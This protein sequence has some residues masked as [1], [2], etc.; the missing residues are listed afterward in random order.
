MGLI[1]SGG[2]RVGGG[3]RKRGALGR[4]RMAGSRTPRPVLEV[5]ETRVL[6]FGGQLQAP[7][8]FLV[9][10]LAFNPAAVSYVSPPPAVGQVYATAGNPI[11]Q[12]GE[13]GPP[14]EVQIR[15]ASLSESAGPGLYVVDQQAPAGGLSV[16]PTASGNS[17]GWV[18]EAGRP[19][20]LNVALIPSPIGESGGTS[21]SS[22]LAFGSATTSVV[23]P[24]T[25][26]FRSDPLGTR[27]IDGPS[28]SVVPNRPF[29]EVDGSL[30]PDR[31]SMNVL[32]PVGPMTRSLGFSVRT[33]DGN[34]APF[35]PVFARVVLFDPAGDPLDQVA[36]DPGQA[37]PPPQVMDVML[38]DAPAGGHVLVEITTAATASSTGTGPTV[39]SGPTTSLSG[40]FVLDIQRQE[41]RPAQPGAPP[42]Q[43]QVAVGTLLFVPSAQSGL[44]SL[45]EAT[46]SLTDATA[47]DGLDGQAL[48]TASSDP[49]AAGLVQDAGDG[50]NVRVPTG[51][52]AS[53]S[54]GPLGPI[55]ASSEA[56]PTP[57]VDRHERGLFQAIDSLDA[58]PGAVLPER[59]SQLTQR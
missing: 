23:N 7:L 13:E 42:A 50:F 16:S 35:A 6:L 18:D 17:Q 24:T 27:S 56:D 59:R 26:L 43:G 31:S 14:S 9:T 39:V 40:S 51:P 3:K 11:A 36:P 20:P 5:L 2:N 30:N 28:W 55:L 48:V 33:G 45:S 21:P 38:H 32:I 46:A 41:D 8:P 19:L 57:A 15:P 58:E 34:D 4:T 53:R 54:A 37:E 22:G 44:S 10:D 1:R 29:V 25:N 49:S 47:A 52:F 12:T